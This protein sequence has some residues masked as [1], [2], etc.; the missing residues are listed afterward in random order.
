MVY[1]L[2]YCTVSLL[3][4]VRNPG[5]LRYG[6][7]KEENDHFDHIGRFVAVSY[8]YSPIPIEYSGVNLY[9]VYGKL[10]SVDEGGISI[11]QSDGESIFL[12][13]NTVHRIEIIDASDQAD[14]PE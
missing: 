5:V 13:T 9:H 10:E 12:P 1:S 3:S 4:G 8:S 2:V 11:R 6:V 7:D 14:F